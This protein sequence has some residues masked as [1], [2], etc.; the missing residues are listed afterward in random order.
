MVHATGSVA[1][2][3]MQFL[4]ELLS[5]SHVRSRCGQST[6][7]DDRSLRNRVRLFIA[8]MLGVP[9]YPEGLDCA[10]AHKFRLQ[11]SEPPD[12]QRMHLRVDC[13]VQNAFYILAVRN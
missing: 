3:A 9:L 6:L 10:L 2:V 11:A 4:E 12:H 13:V 5:E 7:P 8:F 1:V